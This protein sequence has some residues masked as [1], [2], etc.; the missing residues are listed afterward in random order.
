MQHRCDLINAAPEDSDHSC[1]VIRAHIDICEV[2]RCAAPGLQLVL[3]WA[4]Q[5]AR[6]YDRI[7]FRNVAD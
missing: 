2:K 3:D 7:P 5:K 6:L 1:H 4:D